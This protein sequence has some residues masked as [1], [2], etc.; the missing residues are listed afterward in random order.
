MLPFSLFTSV[1][2]SIMLTALGLFVYSNVPNKDV[3]VVISYLIIIS[4]NH[5]NTYK[6]IIN[7][8]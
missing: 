7:E 1:I 8:K 2:F 3:Y 4:N 5:I 6:N